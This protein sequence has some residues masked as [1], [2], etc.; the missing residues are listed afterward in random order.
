MS[1]TVSN[2]VKPSETETVA[3]AVADRTITYPLIGGGFMSVP[4][5]SW[6]IDDHSN[7]I[8]IGITPDELTHRGETVAAEFALQG[9]RSVTLLEAEVRQEPFSSVPRARDPHVLF[10]PD[11]AYNLI[12]DGYLTARELDQVISQLRDH[13]SELMR[14]R[15]KLGEY[16]AESHRQH[17]ADRKVTARRWESLTPT[18]IEAMPVS[19]LLEVFEAVVVECD[20]EELPKNSF[21]T[22]TTTGGKLTITFPRILTQPLRESTARNLLMKHAAT[23]CSAF[24]YEQ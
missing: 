24:R 8:K 21:G 13:T 7:D 9:G 19:Y 22:L 4:C 16:R 23:V 1:I 18:D 5:P 2:P 12:G 10:S 20:A 15:D 11:S 3:E 14:L 6:C 17:I